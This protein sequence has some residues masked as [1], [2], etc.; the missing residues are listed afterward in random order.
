VSISAARRLPPQAGELIDRSRPLTFRWDGRTYPGLQ[1]DTIVS[2]LLASGV[3]VFSRSFKYSRP[4]GVLSASFVD[5]GC[6]VQVDDE[7]NV[8]AGHRRV[9]AGM[10][11]QPQNVWPSLAFDVRS[12]NRLVGRFL[13]AGFYYK[14]FIKPQRLWPS[15]QRVLSRFAAGG[16]MSRQSVHGYYDKRYV[17][18]DV[19]VAGAGPAGIAAAVAAADG[20]ASVLLVEEEYELGGHLRYG[21]QEELTLL[22]DLR[23]QVA[24]R[25]SIEV[26]TDAVV[27]GRYD[28]N[29]VAV[30]QRSVG[31]ALERLV[32]VRAGVLVVAPGLIERPYVFDGNDLPGVLLSTAVRRLVNLYAVRPGDRA[33]VL[34]ANADGDAAAADL[35][36][37]GVDV[38]RVLD[39]RRGETLRR[40]TGRGRVQ[41]VEL[42]DGTVLAADLLV[43]ATGWTAPTSLL[44]MAGDRPVWDA[45]AA[46]FVPSGAD[47]PPTVLATGGLVGDGSAAELVAH[48][49]AV[50]T[51]AAD[52]A[53]GRAGA[54]VPTLPCA[55]HP[56]MFRASTHGFVDFS[57]DVSSKDIVAAAKE[58][59]DSSELVKRFTTATMGPSQGKLETINTI[60]VLGEATGRQVAE[61]GTTVWRPPYAPISLGAL[62]GRVFEPTRVSPMQSWHSEH[63]ATPLLA[64]QWV[65]PDHY[66]DATAEARNVRDNVGIIDVTPLGKLELRGPDVPKL[67]NLVYVNTW[68]SLAVGSVRYGVMCAEDGVVMDDGV[69]GRLAEDRY[70]MSTTS[71]GAATV[72][73]WLESWLQTDRTDWRVHVTPVTTAYA[74]IN[75]AGPRSRELMSRL[76]Q[77]VELSNA[78]FPYMR[79]R[80]GRVA[81]VD[82]CIMWR[83]G[84]TGELS[85]ELHVPASYGRHVWEALLAAGA[86][87]GVRP[88][89]V[90]AQR[91][92]RLEKGHLIVAQDTDGLT[93]AQSAGLGGL[94]KFDKDDF[95]GKPEL[96]WHERYATATAPRLVALRPDDPTVVPPEASQI[97]T[98]AGSI[99]GRITSSRMSPTLGFAVCLG[100]V[101]PAIA[102]SGTRVTVRL[103]SGGDIPAT[104]Q[105]QLAFLDPEGVRLR[106]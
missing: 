24:A 38:V 48:G 75:V 67:L 39:A 46:R 61:L 85:Y 5:P 26:M 106:G 33:V 31:G 80:E 9:A 20:G 2:A 54:D 57:E 50:G 8:R 83:I 55:P 40:A 97:I 45:T 47:L 15:Y 12:A 51:V 10:D 89:G 88:F 49:R 91:M 29:W 71:S 90:E 93:R 101:D 72:W 86:D 102:A 84:F 87:L 44:N 43:T 105:E 1:G 23:A 6:T 32:K 18:V 104:V 42:D 36:R 19:V 98:P 66:G 59:Y 100:Q 60:A 81:G 68:S 64:G 82:D 28:D 21:G 4:R 11:V 63:G 69:T 103:P 22:A 94:V 79:V 41:A 16:L 35:A 27:T 62:A 99:L 53:A 96:A 30:M 76:V 92:L 7:P 78:A 95:A 34:T 37:V 65:R 56:A 73:E 3:T 25:P 74:S 17:H 13:T 52:R 70:L 58:G 14:T 77:G